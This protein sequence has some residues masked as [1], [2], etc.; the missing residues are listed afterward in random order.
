MGWIQGRGE[1]ERPSLQGG[2]VDKGG[3]SLE[4]GAGRME[5]STEALHAPLSLFHGTRQGI[6]IIRSTRAG[7][8][9]HPALYGDSSSRGYFGRAL[10]DSIWMI[11]YQLGKEIIIAHYGAIIHGFLTLSASIG[12]NSM[13]RPSYRNVL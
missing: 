6:K 9:T 12:K 4:S 10:S 5:E 11:F 13:N 7:S 3:L 1:E 8:V 2:D